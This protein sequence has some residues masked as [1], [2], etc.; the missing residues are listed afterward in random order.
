MRIDIGFRYLFQADYY[1][2]KLKNFFQHSMLHSVA[3]FLRSFY[4][5]K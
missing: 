5:L 4:F 3:L 2:M 1:Y